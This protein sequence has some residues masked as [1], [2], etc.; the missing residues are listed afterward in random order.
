MKSEKVMVP[1]QSTS[2]THRCKA[3][4]AN[5]RFALCAKHFGTCCR[6]HS[7]WH[8][9][10]HLDTSSNDACNRPSTDPAVAAGPPGPHAGLSPGGTTTFSTF[11]QNVGFVWWA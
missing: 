9:S 1:I 5:D 2:I 8:R 3:M 11:H 7:R 10:A 6:R 4:A